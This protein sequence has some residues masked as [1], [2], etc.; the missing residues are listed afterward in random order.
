MDIFKGQRSQSGKK[1]GGLKVQEEG[2]QRDILEN[3]DTPKEK[4]DAETKAQEDKGNVEGENSQTTSPDAKRDLQTKYNLRKKPA[5]SA[6]FED[7][8]YEQMLLSQKRFGKHGGIGNLFQLQ[9]SLAANKLK[10][11]QRAS[12]VMKKKLEIIESIEDNNEF[13]DFIAA[14]ASLN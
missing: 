8:Q 7:L 14:I 13:R 12:Q 11:F 10:H 2:E 3:V 5:I 4:E 1:V 6:K 9:N